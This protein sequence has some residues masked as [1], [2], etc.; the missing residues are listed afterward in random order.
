MFLT[1]R[2]YI[3]KKELDVLHIY[4]TFRMSARMQYLNGLRTFMGKRIHRLFLKK[5]Y[6]RLQRGLLWIIMKNYCQSL[7]RRRMVVS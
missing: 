7:N 1:W 2:T 3:E 5:D 4:G 6:W